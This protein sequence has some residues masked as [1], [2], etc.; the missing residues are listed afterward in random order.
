MLPPTIDCFSSSAPDMG[1]GKLVMTK[2]IELSQARLHPIYRIPGSMWKLARYMAVDRSSSG[3]LLITPKL[4]P[5]QSLRARQY[6]LRR[7][8]A[9]T[10]EM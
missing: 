1:H 6:E 5:T 9:R 8:D 7:L 10:L 3:L 4:S 2:V